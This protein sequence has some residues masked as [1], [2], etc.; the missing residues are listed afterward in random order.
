[1]EEYL[2][3]NGVKISNIFINNESK[4]INQQNPLTDIKM[5]ENNNPC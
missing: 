4:R 3:M 2:H 5:V 1:V